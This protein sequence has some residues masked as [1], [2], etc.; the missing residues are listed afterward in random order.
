[1][2]TDSVTRCELPTQGFG[3]G[4]VANDLE[5]DHECRDERMAVRLSANEARRS[6]GRQWETNQVGSRQRW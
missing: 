4:V 5:G 2:I 1:M 6:S 3:L